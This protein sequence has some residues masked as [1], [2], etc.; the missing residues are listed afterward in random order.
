MNFIVR[1]SL[2]LVRNTDNPSILN[3]P[4]AS[5]GYIHWP[6]H[7]GN[8]SLGGKGIK[9][10]PISTGNIVPGVCRKAIGFYPP[11]AG[12]RIRISSPSFSRVFFP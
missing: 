1:N 8:L 4:S 3:Y 9:S 12:G 10:F 11:E 5:A 6:K 7:S 2:F